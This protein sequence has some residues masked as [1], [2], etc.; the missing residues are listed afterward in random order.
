MVGISEK[1]ELR[2]RLPYI[3]AFDPII[4]PCCFETLPPPPTAS[5]FVLHLLAS[6][7]V[8]MKINAGEILGYQ[9]ISDPGVFSAR[10]ARL[11]IFKETSTAEPLM[12][13][14]NMITKYHT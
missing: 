6:S 13:R 5:P 9:S 8:P 4:Y 7:A 12:Y 14:G 2:I 3:L 1:E 10:I 11:G